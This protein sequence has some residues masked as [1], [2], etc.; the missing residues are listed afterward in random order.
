MPIVGYLSNMSLAAKI[1]ILM[2]VGYLLGTIPSAVWVARSYGLDIY[3]VGS[4]NPGASNIYRA[5][6]KKAAALV[7]LM[8]ALKGVIPAALGRWALGGT[9]ALGLVGGAAAVAGHS[10]PVFRRFRG[11]RGVATGAGVLLVCY[12]VLTLIL[13]GVFALIVA[14]AKKPSIG[15]LAAI[16]GVVV[17][18]IVIAP[19]RSELLLVIALVVLVL[20]RHAENIKRLFRGE[21]HGLELAGSDLTSAEGDA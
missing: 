11:G 3:E 21:E 10:W 12:P 20:V 14:V 17:G 9:I 5:L 6:G 18:M 7:F 19:P 8:D 15:S 4:G 2:A 1:P 13:L 16:A